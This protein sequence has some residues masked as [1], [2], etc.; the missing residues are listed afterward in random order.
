MDWITDFLNSERILY[1]SAGVIGIISVMIGLLFLLFSHYKSFAITLMA[2]GIIE[3]IVMF[4]AYLKYQ[5]KIDHKI[6]DY[7]IE[8][9]KFLQTETKSTEKALTSFFWLKLAYGVLI[10][11]F[12]LIISFLDSKSVLFGIF[13]ALTLHLTLAITIDNFGE[14]SAKKYM[15]EL[16]KN[17]V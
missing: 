13:S 6:S 12:S 1:L 4:P 14:K 2:I 8:K 3:I 17:K 5:Q 11:V 7:K 10:V 15:I 16:T 9:T